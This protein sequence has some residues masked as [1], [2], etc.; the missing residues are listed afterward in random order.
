MSSLIFS[1]YFSK[2]FIQ[3]IAPGDGVGCTTELTDW[4]SVCAELQTGTLLGIL[5][6][7]VVGLIGSIL[8]H[9]DIWFG[10]V[11]FFSTAA[12]VVMSRLCK[13][14]LMWGVQKMNSDLRERMWIGPVLAGCQD[15][16]ACLVILQVTRVLLSFWPLDTDDDNL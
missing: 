3:F 5:L 2:L 4:S 8:C 16:V 7:F 15:F 11:T 6:G 9:F 1:L 13:Y 14:C 12:A 10:T